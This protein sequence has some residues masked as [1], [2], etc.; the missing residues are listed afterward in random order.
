MNRPGSSWNVGVGAWQQILSRLNKCWGAQRGG[1]QS[2]GSIRPFLSNGCAHR[3]WLPTSVIFLPYKLDSP[4]CGQGTI[5][6][7]LKLDFFSPG[8]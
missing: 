4:A 2:L 7:P 3:L 1:S 8:T 5:T 6:S